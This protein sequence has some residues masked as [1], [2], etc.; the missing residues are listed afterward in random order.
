MQLVCPSCGTKNRV[1]QVRFAKVG[2]EASPEAGALHRVHSI[3]GRV[4]FHRGQEAA[5]RS[6]AMPA[7]DIVKWLRRQLVQ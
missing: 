6:D 3:P 4:P 2:T 7:Q 1:P 5:S